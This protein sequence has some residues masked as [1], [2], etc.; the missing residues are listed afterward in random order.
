[1]L[2]AHT[3]PG[4]HLFTVYTIIRPWEWCIFSSLLSTLPISRVRV[5]HI[6]YD[7][8][9]EHLA[10]KEQVITLVLWKKVMKFREAQVVTVVPSRLPSTFRC[11]MENPALRGKGTN[12]D[13][14][15]PPAWVR[16]QDSANFTPYPS[17][18]YNT[19]LTPAGCSDEGWVLPLL[20]FSSTL[21][22]SAP[23]DFCSLL[24]SICG[25]NGA[26][27]EPF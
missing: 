11:L 16:S 23:F 25:T 5:F 17:L 22:P 1:M 12:E 24:K 10:K 3:V 21:V 2:R 9:L 7:M 6:I 18:L 14:P 13:L 19:N 4:D 20:T 26:P 27:H 8:T 15:R